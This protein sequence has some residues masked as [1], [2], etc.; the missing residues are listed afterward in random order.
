MIYFLFAY[1]EGLYI[2]PII[3]SNTSQT[4]QISFKIF[5]LCSSLLFLQSKVFLCYQISSTSFFKKLNILNFAISVTWSIIK[6]SF[7][8]YW[9]MLED[10]SHS[11]SS[12]W[13]IWFKSF[14]AAF[15][16]RPYNCWTSS[17]IFFNFFFLNCVI[18]L[19]CDL[20][21]FSSYVLNLYS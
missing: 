9:F 21:W 2:I 17:P 20:I 18:S 19:F 8:F 7:N 15:S 5:T 16:T 11:N 3:H 4:S 14:S 1:A 13:Q 12:K 6:F 10:F